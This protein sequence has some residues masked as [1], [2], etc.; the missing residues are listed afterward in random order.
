MNEN[1]DDCWKINRLLDGNIIS[2]SVKKKSSTTLQEKRGS[3]LTSLKTF[4]IYKNKNKKVNHTFFCSKN[5]SKLSKRSQMENEN[6]IKNGEQRRNSTERKVPD[7]QSTSKDSIIIKPF[8]ELLPKFS[9][10]SNQNKSSNDKATNL[11]TIK[12][13]LKYL[14]YNSIFFK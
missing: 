8:V 1:Y 5:R 12:S 13:K 7:M 14:I 9:S 4:Q 6:S 11:R 10:E 2:F 3:K